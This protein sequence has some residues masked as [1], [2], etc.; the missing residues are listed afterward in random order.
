MIEHGWMQPAVKGNAG[1][2]IFYPHNSTKRCLDPI[3]LERQG[4]P[5]IY[6]TVASPNFATGFGEVEKVNSD[7]ARAYAAIHKDVK[8]MAV[9]GA[10]NLELAHAFIIAAIGKGIV[11]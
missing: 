1:K 9:G 7:L 3:D 2:F 4:L 6:K 5:L 8:F 11:V 10:R